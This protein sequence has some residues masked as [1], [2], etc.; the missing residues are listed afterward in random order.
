MG[1]APLHLRQG[2]YHHTS[3]STPCYNTIRPCAVGHGG[4]RRLLVHPLIH[5]ASALGGGLFHLPLLLVS[6]QASLSLPLHPPVILHF[7]LDPRGGPN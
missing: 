2:N 4:A 1:G 7:V 6:S 5:P 3:L